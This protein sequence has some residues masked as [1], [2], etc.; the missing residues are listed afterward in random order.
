MTD[1]DNTAYNLIIEEKIRIVCMLFDRDTESTEDNSI[2]VILS[3]KKK[4]LNRLY[5]YYIE[6]GNHGALDDLES[7]LARYYN[8]YLEYPVYN[9]ITDL[10]PNAT[11][12]Q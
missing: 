11:T 9:G 2:I 3:N 10:W 5:D 12:L 7:Q 6:T 8:K 1:S 4:E